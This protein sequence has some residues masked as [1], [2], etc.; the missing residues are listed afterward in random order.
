MNVNS[1]KSKQNTKTLI[2]I[3]IM[4]KWNEFISF[5][6]YISFLSI[7]FIYLRVTVLQL[8]LITKIKNYKKNLRNV[9]Y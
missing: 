5:L 3:L 7:P 4:N 1:I 6:Y 9:I 2:T 8:F